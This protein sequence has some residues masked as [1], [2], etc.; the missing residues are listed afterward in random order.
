MMLSRTTAWVGVAVLFVLSVAAWLWL[1]VHAASLNRSV[2]AVV[3]IT[4]M[5]VSAFN[6]YVLARFSTLSWRYLVTGT[7]VAGVLGGAAMIAWAFSLS[8][9]IAISVYSAGVASIIATLVS[10][11][12]WWPGRDD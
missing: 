12:S 1:E 11:R 9:V 10:V 7:P 8:S 2:V 3:G 6:L 4:A 5:T